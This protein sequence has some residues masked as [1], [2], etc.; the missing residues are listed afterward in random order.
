MSTNFT[1][2]NK[3]RDW[4]YSNLMPMY[5]ESE[6]AIM[7]DDEL[8]DIFDSHGYECPDCGELHDGATTGTERCPSC[9]EE[10]AVR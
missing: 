5:S 10:A 1:P 2:L 9:E 4:A 8:Q 7:D 3:L 6:I